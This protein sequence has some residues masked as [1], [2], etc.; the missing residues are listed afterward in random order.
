[1]SSFICTDKHFQEMYNFI[2]H[3]DFSQYEFTGKDTAKK[4]VSDLRK[5]NIKSFNLQYKDN[6]KVD[7]MNFT[8]TNFCISEVEFIKY[9]ECLLYQIELEDTKEMLRLYKI[10]SKVQKKILEVSN[11]A[12]SYN[13]DYEKAGW[14]I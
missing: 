13:V 10:I 3:Q 11:K 1:M 6:E 4:F 9:C 14:G 5:T 12:Y 8:I 2:M 7:W